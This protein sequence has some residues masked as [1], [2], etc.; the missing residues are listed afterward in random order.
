MSGQPRKKEQQ[1]ETTAKTIKIYNRFHATLTFLVLFQ[2]LAL[3]PLLLFFFRVFSSRALFIS[4]MNFIGLKLMNVTSVL[5]SAD[6]DLKRSQT[7]WR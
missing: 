4:R 2:R 5:I 7:G 6:S 1:P 3:T